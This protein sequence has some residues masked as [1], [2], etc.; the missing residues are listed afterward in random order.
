MVIEAISSHNKP[1]NGMPRMPTVVETM[2]MTTVM[3]A[4]RS[5]DVCV[6]RRTKAHSMTNPAP[7]I[8]HAERRC[9]RNNDGHTTLARI[10]IVFCS[11]NGGCGR[12]RPH[13]GLKLSNTLIV[14][15]REN[16]AKTSKVTRRS[17]ALRPRLVGGYDTIRSFNRKSATA[18][19]PCH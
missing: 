16:C 1:D 6:S 19:K 2:F 10:A 18:Q 8:H 7:I 14:W 5:I 4:D 17:R 15:K 13:R 9:V 12:H 3:I 11:T